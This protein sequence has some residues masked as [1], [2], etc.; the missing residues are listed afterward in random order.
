MSMF[1]RENENKT[2]IQTKEEILELEN[3]IRAFWQ[4]LPL[5]ICY[6]NPLNIVLDASWDFERFSGYKATEIVGEN[7]EKLFDSTK[8][9]KEIEQE[10]LEKGRILG[11]ETTFLNKEKRKI[12][13][14]LSA[15]VRKD[16]VDDSIGYFLSI[17]DITTIKQVEN[18]LK[19][20]IDE[21][22]RYKNVTVG[23]E[24]RLIEIKKELKELRTKLEGGK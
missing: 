22:E 4:F 16:K 21:L 17:M 12:P 24:L 15:M 2:E 20:K 11:R 10:I 14:I 13:I 18:E 7:L 6:V 3:Y 9:I 19:K 5:P 1:L 8:E 23:R